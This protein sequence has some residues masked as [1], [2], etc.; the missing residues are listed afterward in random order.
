MTTTL[1]LTTVCGGHTVHWLDDGRQRLG[2]IPGKGGAAAAWLLHPGTA[3]HTRQ[4]TTPFHLWRPWYGDDDLFS[5]ASLPLVPWSN[6]VSGGGFEHGG[7]FHPLRPN[8]DGEALPIHGEGW[9]QAW[10]VLNHDAL[11]LDMRLASMCFMDSPYEYIATQSYRLLPDGIGQTLTVTHLGSTPLPYGLGQHP[12][13]LRTTDTR[14]QGQVKGVWLSH[15]D[16]LPSQHRTAL[17]EWDL[18]TGIPAH[19]PLIDNAFTGWQGAARIEWPEARWALSVEQFGTDSGGCLLV[20]RPESGPT[21]C[22]EPVTHPVDAIHL[23]GQ[24]GLRWLEHGGSMTQDLRWRFR[25]L[26]G[27]A[28]RAS[29]LRA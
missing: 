11:R 23:P 27:A 18:R 2:L 16:R 17:G 9:L 3:S 12:W 6:R 22:V 10:Q 13:L 14:V 4:P 21:F 8:R 7:Q 26:E 19:G 15:P 20:F 25:R 29:S 5:V 24:P 1:P 28:F